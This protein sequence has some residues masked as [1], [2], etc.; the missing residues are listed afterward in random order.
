MTKDTALL[1]SDNLHLVRV[2]GRKQG[3][4]ARRQRGRG[5]VLWWE[6]G[7]GSGAPGLLG[8]G[9]TWAGV[10]FGEFTLVPTEHGLGE[11]RF[12]QETRG[13]TEEAQ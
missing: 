9:V 7:P 13:C 12:G 6:S 8:W 3:S 1:G 10:H 2:P 11:L 5:L 4:R